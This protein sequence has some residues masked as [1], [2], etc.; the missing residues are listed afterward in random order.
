VCVKGGGMFGSL[1]GDT[2][3]SG[4]LRVVIWR[5]GGTRG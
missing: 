1:D 3:R 4:R 5:G 2:E